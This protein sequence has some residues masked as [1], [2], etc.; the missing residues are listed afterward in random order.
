MPII[1]DALATVGWTFLAVLLFYG[2][3]RLFDLLDPI[4]Y[5][6]E[7]RRG[8]IAAGILLAAVIVALAAIIIA[9]IMT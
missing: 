7:I 2:G 9:V 6:T 4:D 3:V 5:Q 8:N 1:Q